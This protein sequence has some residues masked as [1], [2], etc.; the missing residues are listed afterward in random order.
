MWDFGFD[1]FWYFAAA[2]WQILDSYDRS[3]N[4]SNN[5]NEESPETKGEVEFLGVRLTSVEK[6]KFGNDVD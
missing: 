1:V 6:T 3:S 4:F 2:D 5:Q